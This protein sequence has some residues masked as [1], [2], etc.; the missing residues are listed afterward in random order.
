LTYWIDG[1]L[2]NYSLYVFSIL[3]RI[4]NRQGFNNANFVFRS[5]RS[6]SRWCRMIGRNRR[7][8]YWRCFATCY[9]TNS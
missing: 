2:T 8:R 1:A 6:R 9:C 5:I 3:T 7:Q 4:G